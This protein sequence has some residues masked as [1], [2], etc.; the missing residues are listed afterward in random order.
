VPT[1]NLKNGVQKYDL[2]QI[3]AGSSEFSPSIVQNKK[4]SQIF[5]PFITIHR[6]ITG[7]IINKSMPELAF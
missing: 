3:L 4:I 5:T 1:E 7:K 2:K 6:Y